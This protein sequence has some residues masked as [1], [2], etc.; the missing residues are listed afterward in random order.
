M[1][2]RQTPSLGSTAFVRGMVCLTDVFGSHTLSRAFVPFR[3]VDVAC[4]AVLC[5]MY[6]ES[7]HGIQ[8]VEMASHV[9]SFAPCAPCMHGPQI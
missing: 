5:Q 2:T 1:L 9:L 7:L 4:C 6:A 8:A 3:R